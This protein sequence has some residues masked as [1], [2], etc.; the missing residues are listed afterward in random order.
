M[1]IVSKP[2]CKKLK[3]SLY[4]AISAEIYSAKFCAIVL[5]EYKPKVILVAYSRTAVLGAEQWNG[6]VR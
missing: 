1:M 6:F 4:L 5:I 2:G 3:K